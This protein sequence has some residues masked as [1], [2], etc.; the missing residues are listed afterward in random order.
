MF[1]FQCRWHPVSSVLT[2]SSPQLAPLPSSLQMQRDSMETNADP[3]ANANANAEERFC[4]ICLASEEENRRASWVRPCRCSGTTKWV[5][6]SCLHRW[7][8]QKQQGN[9]RRPVACQQCRTEYLLVYPPMSPPAAALEWLELAAR[10]SCPFLAAGVLG[11]CLYWTAVTY[12]AVTVVRLV[13]QRRAL[14]LMESDL[15]LLV[16]L[17]LIPVGLVLAGL[18]RWEDAVLRLLRGGHELLRKLPFLRRA[19]EPPSGHGSSSSSDSLPPIQNLAASSG[20]LHIE[21]V[22][23][24][25]VLLPPAATAV[26]DLLFGSLE[27]PLRRALLGAVCFVGTKGLLKVYLRQKLFLRRRRRRIADFTEENVRLHM[28]GRVREAPPFPGEPNPP[29]E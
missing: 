27:D 3:A 16:G 29:R 23:C 2:S 17:P 18:L 22:L 14:E 21:R 6:Q 19:E 28:G 8:D 25:A 10:R 5:H 11:C 4:W 13:G 20:P 24:G 1:R 9:P 15:L 12:G 7:I 26:G